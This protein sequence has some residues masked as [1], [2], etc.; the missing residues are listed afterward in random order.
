MPYL[1]YRQ[2]HEEKNQ[3]QVSN[4]NGERKSHRM[5]SSF[6]V[7]TQCIIKVPSASFVE[8]HLRLTTINCGDN[9]QFRRNLTGENGRESEDA[10]VR[11]A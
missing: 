9:K 1:E 10:R 7:E 5:I 2:K 6:S 11:R 4:Y 3:L 8:H